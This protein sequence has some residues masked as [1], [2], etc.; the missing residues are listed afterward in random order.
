MSINRGLLNW[1]VFF[2][3]LGAIPL[4]VRYGGLDPAQVDEVWRFWP[5]ILVGIGLGLVLRLTPLAWLGGALVS[6]TLGLIFGA[7]LTTGTS[8]VNLAC[9][10]TGD[11]ETT[12]RSGVAMSA[13][14][15]LDLELTCGELTVSR[16]PE[17]RWTVEAGHAAG[18]PPAVEG[19]SS[20]LRLKYPTENPALFPFADL[21]RVA[22][23]VGL[24]AAPELSVGMTLNMSSADVT[25]GPGPV[26]RIGATYNFASADV[27]LTGASNP[28]AISLSSTY[29]FTSGRLTLSPVTLSGSLTLNFSSLE[30]CLDPSAA[31]R[32]EHKGTLSSDDLTAS[33]LEEAGQGWQT[34]GFSAAK[35]RI[36]LRI[37]STFSSLDI[38]RSGACQ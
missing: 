16:V 23:D 21:A 17:A 24:P 19:S 1:G 25:L 38:D 11:D 8:G 30:V 9:M 10:G 13:E 18:K 22:W 6:A 26:G 12:S 31:A 29:N 35:E 37:T 2:V 33:G 14:F 4:A 5:L 28:A 7:L 20:D 15:G 3:V 34:P 32:I 36:E 27:D